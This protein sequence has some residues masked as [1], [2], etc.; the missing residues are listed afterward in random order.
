MEIFWS[1]A[2][3]PLA[4]FRR[5]NVLYSYYHSVQLLAQSEKMNTAFYLANII[6]IIRV[7]AM[8]VMLLPFVSEWTRF[9]LSDT[10]IHMKVPNGFALFYFM[11][12]IQ[13]FYCNQLL[14]RDSFKNDF[15]EIPYQIVLQGKD[16]VFI[17]ELAVHPPCP[18]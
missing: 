18:N 14:Y 17:S 9:V 8:F 16:N 10:T 7:S 13:V 12:V 15:S 1:T 4:T 2:I 11:L 6:L 5:Q 3:N